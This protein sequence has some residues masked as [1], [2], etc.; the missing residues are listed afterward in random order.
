MS[1]PAHLWSAAS[2]SFGPLSGDERG[3]LVWAFALSLTLHAV[4][5]L[6]PSPWQKPSAQEVARSILTARL[7]P[8]EAE[9]PPQPEPAEEPVVKAKVEEP[10]KAEIAKPRPKPRPKERPVEK[11]PEPLEGQQL[12]DALA[13]LAD[14][15]LYPPEAI[16]Q[17][18]EGETLLVLDVGAGGRIAMASI[19]ASSGHPV[20][21]QAALRA[22]RQVGS[23]SPTLAGRSILLPVRFRLL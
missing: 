23:L 1:K 5:M 17:G 13:Q 11:K 21:D 7:E 18:L 10:I 15:L 12:D 14:K 6:L 8:R 19:A 2:S 20:L 16:K 3:L 4:S 9:P 22:V